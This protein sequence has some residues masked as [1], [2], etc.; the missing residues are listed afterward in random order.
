MSSEDAK[1]PATAS[2]PTPPARDPWGSDPKYPREYWQYEVNNGDTSLGYWD[3]V[4]NQYD[5]ADDDEEAD[6]GDDA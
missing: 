3:W 6:A 1:A 5:L 4:D 2:A